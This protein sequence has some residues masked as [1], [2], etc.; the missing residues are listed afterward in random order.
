[1][2]ATFEIDAQDLELL[3]SR[4]QELEKYLGIDEL[5][6]DMAYF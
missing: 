3:E 1:M 5:N 6:W 2:E 4:V